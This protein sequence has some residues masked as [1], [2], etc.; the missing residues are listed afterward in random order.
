M[1]ELLLENNL[2]VKV[3]RAWARG[4]AVRKAWKTD[5]SYHSLRFHLRGLSAGHEEYEINS[6]MFSFMMFAVY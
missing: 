5:S 4:V 3:T 1:T 2:N 6:K